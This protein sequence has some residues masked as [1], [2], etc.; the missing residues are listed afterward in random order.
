M[1]NIKILNYCKVLNQDDFKLSLIN[2]VNLN[3]LKA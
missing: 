2:L 1:Q 3:T